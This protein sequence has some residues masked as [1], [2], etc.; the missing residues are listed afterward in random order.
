MSPLSG[1]E[2]GGTVVQIDVGPYE[3]CPLKMDAPILC[4]FE[5][6]DHPNRFAPGT[7]VRLPSA[8]NNTVECVSP[9][10]GTPDLVKVSYAVV[11]DG[12][13]IDQTT[14]YGVEEQFEY[15]GHRAGL[16]VD[17]LR[18]SS[19]S[20][21]QLFLTGDTIEVEWNSEALAVSALRQDESFN[22]A[23]NIEVLAYNNSVHA[24]EKI[25]SFDGVPAQSNKY[26][27]TLD[28]PLTFDMMDWGSMQGERVAI[29]LVRVV[30]SFNQFF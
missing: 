26:H 27:F 22:F 8:T 7:Y 30:A 3:S 9:F 21:R 2:V 4:L 17:Y 15:I 11:P 18:T 25:T 1:L 24:F 16:I 10:S 20:N 13:T 5:S 6:E 19:P 28:D 14:F 29:I 23:V 12:C